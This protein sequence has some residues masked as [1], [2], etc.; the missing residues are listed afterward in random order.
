MLCCRHQ[1]EILIW[2]ACFW[3]SIHRYGGSYSLL[4]M[5]STLALQ[6]TPP[7]MCCGGCKMES[8]RTSAPRWDKPAT[9]LRER[10]FRTKS[11]YSS[12]TCTLQQNKLLHTRFTSVI[13]TTRMCIL[14]CTSLTHK[15]FT[16]FMHVAV[17]DLLIFL[18][19]AG[20][21]GLMVHGCQRGEFAQNSFCDPS[22]HAI[23]FQWTFGKH[24]SCKTVLFYHPNCPHW[25]CWWYRHRE[26][27][28]LLTY[29]PDN[30][31]VPVQYGK[32]EQ[33]WNLILVIYLDKYG[34][35]FV[36]QT[37]APILFSNVTFRISKN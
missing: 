20:A 10:R 15:D 2:N 3:L 22:S 9:I 14:C 8:W 18:D 37:V 33:V 23:K 34:K 35:I 21:D 12:L 6:G 5:R 30:F 16:L 17:P 24:C 26:Q 32:Y 25:L 28:A 1:S 27:L 31:T 7:V 11:F 36:F 29:Y 13:H 4:S 19:E